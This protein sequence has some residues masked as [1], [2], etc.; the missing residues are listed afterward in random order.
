MTKTAL[1]AF[2]LAAVMMNSATPTA[3]A[4]ASRTTAAGKKI[5]EMNCAGCHG[6][7]GTGMPGVF[8]SLAANP[9]V[10][11]D[12]KRVIHT[13]KYGLTGP[14]DV[15]GVKYNGVMPPWDGTLTD[16]QIADVI[17]YVRTTWGNKGSTVAAA[18]VK[19]VA[20]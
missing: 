1:A 10:S 7:K 15:K 4:A 14:I 19:S 9:Y 18:D 3:S 5:F 11:G 6:A 2:V 8:P 16:R 17:T 13:V 12:P 20:K